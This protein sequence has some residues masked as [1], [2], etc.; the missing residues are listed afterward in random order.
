M[1]DRLQYQINMMRAWIS[2]RAESRRGWTEDDLW[3]K[4]RKNW[5]TLSEADQETIFQQCGYKRNAQG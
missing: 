3:M 4:I 1:A 2:R 5:P